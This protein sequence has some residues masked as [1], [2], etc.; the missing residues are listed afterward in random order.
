ME[1]FRKVKEAF[2]KSDPEEGIK[3]LCEL[4]DFS[5]E[6]ATK[7]MQI[8]QDLDKARLNACSN[9]DVCADIEVE[10]S[11]LFLNCAAMASCID[12]KNRGSR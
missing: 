4:C 9:E 5:I 2:M 8:Y 1:Y 6:R 10:K 7:L 11:R 3:L 12:E